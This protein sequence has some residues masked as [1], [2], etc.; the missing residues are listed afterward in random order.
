[1]LD[2]D[3]W[4]D[5]Y[6]DEPCD[7]DDYESD[8]LSGRAHCFRCGHSWCLTDAELNREIEHMAKYQEMID[9][10]ERWRWLRDLREAVL[11]PF[12]WVKD[13]LYPPPADDGIPF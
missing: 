1:M 3:Q 8:L 6:E 7:H 5:G 10:M 2:N 11:A 4:D 13:R 9:R 12:R